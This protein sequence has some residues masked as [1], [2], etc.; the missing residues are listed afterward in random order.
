MSY[1]RPLLSVTLENRNALRSFS[2]MPPRNC[3]RTSGCIS[4]SLLIARCTRMSSPAL[5][6][7]SRCSCRSAYLRSA[8]S[9]DGDLHLADQAAPFRLLGL[10]ELGE[11]LGAAA[12]DLAAL[13]LQA[14]A[15]TGIGEQ[16][17]QDGVQALEHRL[18]HLRPRKDRRPGLRLEAGQRLGDGGQVRIELRALGG[19][20]RQRGQFAGLDVLGNGTA[21]LDEHH[22][23]LAGHQVLHRRAAAAIV[24]RYGLDARYLLEEL[25][26]KAARGRGPGRP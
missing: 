26:G 18:W 24:D 19:T 4:V 16:F 15:N 7:A 12:D 13:A 17:H 20:D 10:D 9:V 1:L 22:L 21:A 11:R 6:R 14:L 25:V 8:I 5:S 2:A 23:H 3:Q